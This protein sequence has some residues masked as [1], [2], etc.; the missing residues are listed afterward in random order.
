MLLLC[1]WF[2]ILL[3]FINF[4]LALSEE[5]LTLLH[6]RIK[7]R[8]LALLRTVIRRQVL[9]DLKLNRF[10]LF[11]I[12]LR[13]LSLIISQ[14]F[15]IFKVFLLFLF[16]INNIKVFLL[17]FAFNNLIFLFPLLLFRLLFLWFIFDSLFFW[18]RRLIRYVWIM[19]TLICSKFFSFFLSGVALPRWL[20]LL[21]FLSIVV[22][23]V[24]R[25][26]LF[27]WFAGLTHLRYF[28]FPAASS[29]FWPLAILFDKWSRLYCKLHGATSF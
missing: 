18:F 20:S 10:I 21:L 27:F 8:H 13:L 9:I 22:L 15:F 23:F 4:Y 6:R 25:F 7:K 3:L 19:N 1:F 24:I 16:W 5:Y 2:L 28:W 17:L 14:S 29:V 26:R 12:L 11:F